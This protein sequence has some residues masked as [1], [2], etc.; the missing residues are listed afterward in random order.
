[1]LPGCSRERDDPDAK[2]KS[3]EAVIYLRVAS[4]LYQEA[5]RTAPTKPKQ[6]VEAPSGSWWLWFGRAGRMHGSRLATLYEDEK[7]GVEAVTFKRNDGKYEHVSGDG[8]KSIRLKS[9][10]DIDGAP[11]H[12]TRKR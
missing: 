2:K 1:M 4:E 10:E 11:I 6:E 7:G 3:A 8:L 5:Q 9:S 12:S